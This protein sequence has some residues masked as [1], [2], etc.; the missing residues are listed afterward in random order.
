MSETGVVNKINQRSQFT[1]QLLVLVV[2]VFSIAIRW[3]LILLNKVPFNS[4]E[5]IVGLMARHILAGEHP[6]FFYGQSYMGSLDAYLVAG[7]FL[8]FG[9]TVV[10]IR[11]TQSVLFFVFL[12]L[13]YQF[14]SRLFSSRKA[15]LVT[16]IFLGAAPV[17]FL[18]YTTVTLGGY[19]ESMIIGVAILNIVLKIQGMLQTKKS[20]SPY[21]FV[22]SLILGILIG[23]GAWVLGITIVFSLTALILF[24]VFIRKYQLPKLNVLEMILLMICGGIIGAAPIWAF[25]S[26]HGIAIFIKELFGSAIAITQPYLYQMGMHLVNLLLFGISTILGF[27]PPWE[28]RWLLLPLIPFVLGAWGFIFWKTVKCFRNENNHLWVYIWLPS[29]ILITAFIL[30]PFGIDPSG[31]YF[32]PVHFSLG[33]HGWTLVCLTWSSNEN[34]QMGITGLRPFIQSWRDHAGLH[35]IPRWDHNPVCTQY[36]YRSSLM[37]RNLITFLKETSNTHGYSTYWA[38]YPISISIR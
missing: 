37:I 24:I 18:L 35:P 34:N 1:D 10:A 6:I 20:N 8:L 30:T 5:A 7:A 14:A 26:N 28:V 33:T 38:A 16:I 25:L 23:L 27:R 29:I 21:L 13:S 9:K 31:R 22:H 19:L 17:N 36:K 2:I 12:L 32:L 3:I 11:I 15:A 4:D